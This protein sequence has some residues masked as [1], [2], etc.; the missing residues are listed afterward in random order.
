MS[1]AR[2]C[3]ICA[4]RLNPRRGRW[5]S[6]GFAP[7]GFKPLYAPQPH[8]AGAGAAC[9][10]LPVVRPVGRAAAAAEGNAPR[11]HRAQRRAHRRALAAAAPQRMDAGAA[12]VRGRAAP[13]AGEDLDLDGT[14]AT[15]E[16]PDS[17]QPPRP[18]SARDFHRR[19]MALAAFHADPAEAMRRAAARILAPAAEPPAALIVDAPSPASVHRIVATAQRVRGPP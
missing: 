6:A 2:N 15:T 18:R 16:I 11:L 17:F 12:P 8:L 1:P 3:M 13:A 10:R 19:T 14:P 9:P 5:D 4:L 7:S